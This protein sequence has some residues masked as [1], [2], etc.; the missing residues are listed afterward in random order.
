MSLTL[1]NI[2][3]STLTYNEMDTNFTYLET[4]ATPYYGSMWGDDSNISIG[5]TQSEL[6][7]PIPSG[8]TAGICSGF[9]FQN[10]KELKC[11][12]AG[13]Y[14]VNWAASIKSA[15]N[16]TI[17]GFVVIDGVEQMN[18]S[19]AVNLKENNVEYHI[20]G[21]GIYNLTANKLVSLG[22]ESEAG[23]GTLIITHCNMT[24][25]KV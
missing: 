8:L 7:V 12:N 4:L 16:F 10:S 1:R 24:I 3:G 15:T 14:V 13:T 25:V 9:T 2:K 19:N 23:T 6:L 11:L 17:E 20:S 5:I 18:S 22:F 21:T